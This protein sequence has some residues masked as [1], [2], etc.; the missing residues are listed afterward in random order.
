[1][2]PTEVFKL[3]LKNGDLDPNERLAF[4][5]TIRNGVR[6]NHGALCKYKYITTNP[7]TPSDYERNFAERIMVISWYTNNNL[8]K[9]GSSSSCTSLSSFMRY[10]LYYVPNV[11][12]NSKHKNKYIER[13]D[14][15]IPKITSYKKYWQRRLIKKWHDFL[16][17]NILNY[18]EHVDVWC[19][20]YNRYQ[21]K[22]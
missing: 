16:K 5:R 4:I 11:I 19:Y 7:M 10:F 20:P 14:V 6:L 1:M 3:F 22:K 9:D 13:M 12:G 15:E 17:E 18:D 2:T 8:G 21:L